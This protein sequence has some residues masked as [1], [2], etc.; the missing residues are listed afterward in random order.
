YV[1]RH[2]A[3]RVF[4][5]PQAVDNAFWSTPARPRADE[6]F[7]ALFVGRP[8]PEKGL[9][10]ALE[11]WR[12]ANVDGTLTVVGDLAAQLPPGVVAAGTLEPGELRN[13]YAAADVL[14]VPSVS[15]R[16]FIEPWGLVVNE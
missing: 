2:G 15:T 12:C 14:L 10:V 16:R 1:R 6:R 3:R 9:A 11:A 5:A 13:F 8:A 4:V 7:S